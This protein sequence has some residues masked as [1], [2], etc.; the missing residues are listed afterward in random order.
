MEKAEREEIREG[1]ETQ[2]KGK[3]NSCNVKLFGAVFLM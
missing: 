3:R 2:I 1:S